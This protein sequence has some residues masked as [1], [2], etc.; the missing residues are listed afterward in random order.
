MVETVSYLFRMFHI[1]RG[2][3]LIIFD[4]VLHR[5]VY[6]VTNFDVISISLF[7]VDVQVVTILNKGL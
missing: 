5:S 4:N 7:L 6:S 2:V 3:F 1:L